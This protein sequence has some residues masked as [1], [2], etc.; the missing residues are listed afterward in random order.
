[1]QDDAIVET[2]LSKNRVGSNV[3]P[4]SSTDSAGVISFGN[5]HQEKQKLYLTSY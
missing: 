2:W 5:D 4:G 1:M 3:I